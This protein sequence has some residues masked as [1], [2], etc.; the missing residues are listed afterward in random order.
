MTNN[1]RTHDFFWS[2]ISRNTI[3]TGL[4]TN[5]HIIYELGNFLYTFYSILYQFHN[6]S[7]CNCR[8]N[9]MCSHQA[10]IYNWAGRAD[11]NV[12][13]IFRDMIYDPPLL[14]EIPGMMVGCYPFTSLFQSRIISTDITDIHPRICIDFSH[15]IIIISFYRRD[16]C[17]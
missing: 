11:V 4:R 1:K 5:Y 3:L 7:S 16:N 15:L 9:D 8:Q 12:S 2:S 13:T 10:S 17:R 14:F 6:N